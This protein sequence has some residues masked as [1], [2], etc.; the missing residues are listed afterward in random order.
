[1]P[2]KQQAD[3]FSVRRR[4][5]I[6]SPRRKTPATWAGTPRSSL[7]T[8]EGRRAPEHRVTASIALPSAPARRPS[9]RFSESS[10]RQVAAYEKSEAGSRAKAYASS[11]FASQAF[12]RGRFRRMYPSPR[13]PF[14]SQPFH[15]RAPQKG[16]RSPRAGHAIDQ[17]RLAFSIR[18]NPRASNRE[19]ASTRKMALLV[20]NDGHGRLFPAVSL[21]K[22]PL[23]GRRTKRR[24]H[25]GAMSVFHGWAKAPCAGPLHTPPSS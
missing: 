21:K 11:V 24:Q 23:N 9:H 25:R 14:P 4:H 3:E 20:S 13:R 18:P 16:T 17:A 8:N 7:T 2:Q 15:F 10:F 1:M 22:A 6:T 19:N 5:T 12:T